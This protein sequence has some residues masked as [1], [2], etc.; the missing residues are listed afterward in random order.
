MVSED[1]RLPRARPE[2]EVHRAIRDALDRAVAD[3]QVPTPAWVREASDVSARMRSTMEL[4]E[5]QRVSSPPVLMVTE[6]QRLH[7]RRLLEASRTSAPYL[8]IPAMLAPPMFVVDPELTSA[9]RGDVVARIGEVLNDWEHGPDAARWVPEGLPTARPSL[10]PLAHL[11]VDATGAV[12]F[13][14]DARELTP[15]LAERLL[16]VITPTVEAAVGAVRQFAEAVPW[17]V[18]QLQGFLTRVNEASGYTLA[19]PPLPEDP[20]E[21]ALQARRRR[22]TGPPVPPPGARG[23]RA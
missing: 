14:A 18:E 11:H 4:L 12:R 13:G 1:H 17:V 19:P 3:L 16:A 6:A 22:G 15:E 7:V 9:P 23:R 2:Q 10:G 8:A 5:R 20:R 21:R